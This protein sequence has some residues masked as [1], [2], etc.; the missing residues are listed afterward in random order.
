MKSKTLL[1]FRQSL[2]L[3]QCEH[4]TNDNEHINSII[5]R[6]F[7]YKA[8]E[9]P[10]SGFVSFAKFSFSGQHKHFVRLKF[11][12]VAMKRFT[13]AIPAHTRVKIK[14]TFDRNTLNVTQDEH[15]H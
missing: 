8:H 2:G 4:T 10:Y 5:K 12:L 3:G 7:D 11:S 9:L 14:T 13:H 15:R 6:K 1:P